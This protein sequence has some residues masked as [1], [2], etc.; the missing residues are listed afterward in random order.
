MPVKEAATFLILTTIKFLVVLII[1]CVASSDS[2]AAPFAPGEI[3]VN[4]LFGNNLQRY[5]PTGTLLQTFNSPGDTGRY[6][7]ALTPEGNL[8]TERFTAETGGINVFNPAGTLIGGFDAS[9]FDST[10]SDIAVFADGDLARSGT[11]TLEDTI[12]I[13][14]PSGVLL[15]SVDT[16]A[17]FRAGGF[18]VGSD[19]VLYVTNQAGSGIAKISAAGIYLGTIPTTFGAEDLV[20]SPSDG[21]LWAS[22]F[23]GNMAVHFETDGTVLGSFSTGLSGNFG[24]IGL[25]PDGNSLYLSSTNIIRHFSLSG[26][27]LGDFNIVNSNAPEFL[28]VVPNGP[29]VPEPSTAALLVVACVVELVVRRPR[30][31]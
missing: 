8:A 18:T 12:G 22:K 17:G 10:F 29:A 16:P 20:M 2:S 14:S 27:P 28:T 23:N 1:F 6:A 9:Q 19:N 13:F 15:H 11:G 25:A 4:N 7:A 3:L 31:G 30:G 5:S 21:T 24:G 26:T